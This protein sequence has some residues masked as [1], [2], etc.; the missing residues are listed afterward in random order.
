MSV[1]WDGIASHS[2]VPLPKKHSG[3]KK[4]PTV[5]VPRKILSSEKQMKLKTVEKE[6]QMRK[7]ESERGHERGKE[8]AADGLTDPTQAKKD[9]GQESVVME[10]ESMVSCR[11]RVR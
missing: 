9:L 4:F 11:G 3:F 1:Y 10:Q 5:R 2:P 7:N 6:K 8:A